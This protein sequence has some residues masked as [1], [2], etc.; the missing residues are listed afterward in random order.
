MS[1]RLAQVR[2]SDPSFF[3]R[4][5]TE[6][7]LL[8]A[9]VFSERLARSGCRN[10]TGL[11]DVSAAC[12]LQRV[13]CILLDEQHTRPPAVD[14]NNSSENALDDPR[15]EPQRG[16]IKTKQPRFGHHCAAKNQHLLFAAA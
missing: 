16:F 6:I 2:S 7:G 4:G 5:A 13:T 14:R 12:S 11:Q 3:G 8:D 10:R 15:C 1:C 9:L